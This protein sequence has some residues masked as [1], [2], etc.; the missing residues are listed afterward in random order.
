MSAANIRFA[1]AIQAGFTT[2]KQPFHDTKAVS[3]QPQEV[4]YSSPAYIMIRRL[5]E[6][7]YYR[8][9]PDVAQTNVPALE[10]DTDGNV[11]Q[12]DK[13]YRQEQARQRADFHLI[14]F[15]RTLLHY[16]RVQPGRKGGLKD[17]LPDLCQQMPSI[18]P[19]DYRRR[20]WFGR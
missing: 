6:S 13:L 5:F 16:Q 9:D 18:V 10:I 12:R 14:R 4:V 15:A 19:S 17:R 7:F 1:F 20:S 3:V 2:K 8:P 11:R